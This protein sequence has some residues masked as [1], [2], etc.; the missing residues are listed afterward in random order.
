MTYEEARNLVTGPFYV[1]VKAEGSPCHPDWCGIGVNP[2]DHETE[3]YERQLNAYIE[4]R[5]GVTP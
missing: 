4:Y 3:W 1:P 5:F 2:Q